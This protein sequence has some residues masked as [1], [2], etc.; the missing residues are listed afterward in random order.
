ME[1]LIIGVILVIV[2]AYVSTKI[3]KAANEAY[4]QENF[5]SEHF[6]IIKPDGF[7]IPIKNESAF[8]FEA[9]SKDLGEELIEEDFY[10]CQATVTEKTGIEA[11]TKVVEAERLEKGISFKT[12]SKTLNNKNNSYTLEIIVLPEYQEKY[13]ERIN[14][15]LESFS[16]K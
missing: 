3:K 16:L 5:E 12:F 4:E 1:I 6:R 15:M 11:G 10:Q 2:M 9:Y 7:I 13:Q 14:L 8:L